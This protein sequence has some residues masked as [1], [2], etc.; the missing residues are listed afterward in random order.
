MG[1]VYELGKYLGLKNPP[2]RMEC[3]DISHIQ[4]SETVASMVVFEGGLPKK[5]DYRRFKI[6]TTEGKP[7]DF[8]SMRE[9]TSRRY[10]GLK[11]WWQGAAIVGFGN[12]SRSWRT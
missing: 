4:G 2:V 5:S 12:N 11:E 7:D 9:V 8:L 3:F 10:V 6:K 1:A